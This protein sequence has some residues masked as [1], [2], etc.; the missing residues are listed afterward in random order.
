LVKTLKNLIEDD[1]TIIVMKKH[2]RITISYS[3]SLVNEKEIDFVITEYLKHREFIELEIV[4]NYEN[5][6]LVKETDSN[7]NV[8]KKEIVDT[9]SIDD[10]F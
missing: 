10:K 5:E 3:K 7:K 1:V 4:F 6:V 2:L 9:L 8:I